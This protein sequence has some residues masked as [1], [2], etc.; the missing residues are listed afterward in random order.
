MQGYFIKQSCCLAKIQLVSW[1]WNNTDTQ[2]SQ[3]HNHPV[4][5]ITDEMFQQRMAYIHNNPVAPGFVL[6]PEDYIYAV[7]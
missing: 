5:L 4:E 1:P 7:Q 6:S 3:Q 2:F